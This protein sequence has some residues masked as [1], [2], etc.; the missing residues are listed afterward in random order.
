M[1]LPALGP[2]THWLPWLIAASAQSLPLSLSS[3]G[4]VMSLCLLLIRTLI[5]GFRALLDSLGS[6]LHLKNFNL[7]M[8]SKTLSPYQVTFTGP[9]D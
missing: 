8:S 2:S 7:I 6:S 9:R 5:F 1:P 3:S 4:C